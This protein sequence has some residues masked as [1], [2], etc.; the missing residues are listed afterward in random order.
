MQAQEKHPGGLMVLFFTEMWERFSY[1]GMRALLVLYLTAELVDGGF[2]LSRADALQIYAVFTGLVYLTPI[3]GGFLADNYLGQRKAVFIGAIL[4]AIGHFF[5]AWSEFGEIGTREIIRNNGLGLIIVGTG[6]LKANISTIVGQLYPEN[7]PRKDSGFTLFYMGINVGALIGPVIAGF[8]GENINWSWGFV[9][10]GVGMIIG[11]VWFFLQRSKLE[12]AGMPPNRELV[13]G[14]SYYALTNKDRF[15]ILAYVL[16]NIAIVAG[17]I[18]LWS[19]SSDKIH[20]IA[21][22]IVGLSGLSYLLFVIIRNTNGKE[23]WDKMT[24]LFILAIFNVF[25][26]SG[27]EQAGGTFNL[28]AD[29]NTQRMTRVGEIPAAWF[30]S[31]PALF[32]VLFAGLFASLW[33]ILHNRNRNP[34]T[35]VKFALGLLLMSIGFLIISRGADAAKGGVLVGPYWLV[36]TFLFHTLGELCLSPIGLS[37]VTKLSPPKIVS[38]MMGVWFGSVAAANYLAGMLESILHK[39]LPDMHLFVFL[40]L[41]TLIGG[42]IL[43]ALS[44]LLQKK[45]REVH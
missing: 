14:S 33:M 19:H 3:L 43:L 35:P 11:T 29:E 30:Q 41:T 18:F 37:V 34:R 16:V 31:V 6:F 39:Y 1:Y 8:L 10:A 38:I 32:V 7:D 2:G 36:F 5:M 15:D 24:V 40:T 9:S 4:M 23:A 22:W 20:S 21:L 28:F 13:T 42:C 26:W 27:Y 17:V 45:M 44:P 25:F 12:F